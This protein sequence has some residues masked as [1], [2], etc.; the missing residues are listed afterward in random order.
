VQSGGA[1]SAAYI[2][3]C[4][5]VSLH[6]HRTHAQ[7][8][9]TGC[10]CVAQRLH[11]LQA[12]APRV[13]PV[14]P[15]NLYPDCKTASM[16]MQAPRDH[17][18]HLGALLGCLRKFWTYGLA[19]PTPKLS[20]GPGAAGTPASPARPDHAHEAL[21]RDDAPDRALQQGAP[22]AARGDAASA[23][24]SPG[25]GQHRAYVPPHL[26]HAARGPAPAPSLRRVTPSAGASS[27]AL[28]AVTISACWKMHGRT[29][30]CA[31]L[32]QCTSWLCIAAA[33]AAKCMRKRSVVPSR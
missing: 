27:S 28:V 18:M 17:N 23:S 29:C 32:Q 13:L 14:T 20:A 21:P 9:C 16:I 11:V 30:C 15:M 12:W 3:P 2:S 10:H 25:D 31:S 6:M 19:A 5:G 33:A 22:A 26:R 1:G 24:A 8:T 7:G 4:Y